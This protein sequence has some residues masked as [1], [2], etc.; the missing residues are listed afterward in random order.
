MT[1]AIPSAAEPE[2][3]P[4][5]NLPLVEGLKEDPRLEALFDQYPNLRSKLKYIFDTTMSDD[6]PDDPIKSNAL[7]QN[8]QVSPQK[9]MAHALR[10]L[11]AQLQSDTSEASGL[12]AFAELVTELRPTKPD[13]GAD[14]A[15][16]EP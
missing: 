6:L 10:I 2:S 16:T 3:V 13:R 4:A 7:R 9:R 5:G 11:G 14:H 8:Y 1:T 15:G 12:K